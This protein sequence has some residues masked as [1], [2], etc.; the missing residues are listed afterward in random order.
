[1]LN[2]FFSTNFTVQGSRCTAQAAESKGK[3]WEKE[4]LPAVSENQVWD[5]LQY[6]KVHNSMGPNKIHPH[7]LRELGD[8][9]VKPLSTIFEKSWQSGKVPT[10]W[11]MGNITPI[12]KK[13]KKI[14]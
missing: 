6:L 8:E 3:D 13:E 9:V 10:D 11:K 12:F 14:K 7:I 2:V 1:M 4:T 5:H